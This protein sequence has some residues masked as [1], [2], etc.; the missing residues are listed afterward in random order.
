MSFR[1]LSLDSTLQGHD[2]PLLLLRPRDF[3][4]IPLLCVVLVAPLLAESLVP[5]AGHPVTEGPA[6]LHVAGTGK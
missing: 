4:H 1:D 5:D 6:G 2:Q 3:P